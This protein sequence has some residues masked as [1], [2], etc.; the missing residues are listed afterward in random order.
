MGLMLICWS[1]ILPQGI[2]GGVS[3]HRD[4]EGR[5]GLR[6]TCIVTNSAQGVLGVLPPPCLYGVHGGGGCDLRQIE[7]VGGWARR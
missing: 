5:E 7:E 1:P 3:G 2:P 6:W 4:L